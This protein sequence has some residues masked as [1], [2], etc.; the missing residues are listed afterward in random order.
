[1]III[2]IGKIIIVENT[3]RFKAVG[4]RRQIMITKVI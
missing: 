1:M 4:G 2:D 3:A